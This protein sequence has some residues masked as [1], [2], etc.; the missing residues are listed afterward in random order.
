MD[1]DTMGMITVVVVV[2]GYRVW[3]TVHSDREDTVN[4]ATAF[5]K[6][7]SKNLEKFQYKLEDFKSVR[8]KI[9]I[10]KFMI[11]SQDLSDVKRIH[12]EI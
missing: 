4:R 2:M 1:T 7:L 9:N 12:T 8:K 10:Q 5:R 3:C 6:E 11:P